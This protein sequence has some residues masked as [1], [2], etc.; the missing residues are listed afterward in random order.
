MYLDFLLFEPWRILIIYTKIFARLHNISL[1]IIPYLRKRKIMVTRNVINIFMVQ[2]WEKKWKYFL[3]VHLCKVSNLYY[4]LWGQHMV[5][6]FPSSD[7]T[8]PWNYFT[9]V[10]MTGSQR[11]FMRNNSG[12]GCLVLGVLGRNWSLLIMKK[13]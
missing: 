6:V 2:S 3:I 10:R 5:V 9:F 8:Y 11:R 12:F 4:L 13:W 7:K 1:V